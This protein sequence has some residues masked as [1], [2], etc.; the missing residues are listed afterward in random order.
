LLAPGHGLLSRDQLVRP[1][2][3]M[4]SDKNCTNEP[5]PKHLYWGSKGRWFESSRPDLLNTGFLKPENSSPQRA[6]YKPEKHGPTA[7]HSVTAASSPL[8]QSS[9]SGSSLA[10]SLWSLEGQTCSN[11]LRISEP[12]RPRHR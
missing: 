10:S 5:V 7:S 6:Q 3:L 1:D 12:T 11:R 2:E 4:S 8:G 9:L